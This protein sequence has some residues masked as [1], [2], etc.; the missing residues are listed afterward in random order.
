[1][2]SSSSPEK[3]DLV[4]LKLLPAWVKESSEA[5]SYAHYEGEGDEKERS[6]GG[7]HGSRDRRQ[8]SGKRSKPNFQQ[9]AL[10]GAQR[11]RMG[12]RSNA[13]KND[14]SRQRLNRKGGDHRPHRGKGPQREDRDQNLQSGPPPI[15]VRFLPHPAAIKNVGAQIKSDSLA[16]SLFSIARLFLEKPER[17]DVCLTAKP[18]S[19]LY[20]LG[21]HGT[22]SADRQFLETNAFRLAREDFYKIDITQAEPIKG[23]FSSV[24]KCRLSGTLL[25]PTNH[26]AYQPQLRNLYESRF[27]RRMRK[28]T[29]AGFRTAPK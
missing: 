16:Y 9:P 5:K 20:Q 26:H 8:R 7:D 27:S 23:N 21:E 24:A 14:R 17:Y 4:D 15:T 19:H 1:M 12:P 6:R 10:S 11:S 18:E 2:M 22:I 25:G 3:I 13:D 29:W 28:R